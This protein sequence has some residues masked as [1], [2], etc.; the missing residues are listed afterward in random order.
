[1]DEHLIDESVLCAAYREQAKHYSRILKKADAL[2]AAVDNDGNIDELTQQLTG[3][4]DQTAIA[5]RYIKQ[6]KERWKANGK[7]PGPQLQEAL[8]HI[9]HLIKEVIDRVQRAEQEASARQMQLLPEI[10]AQSRRRMMQ[11]VYGSSHKWRP[12]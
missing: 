5:D 7:K 3:A 10:E 2:L 9:G 1:M 4:L 12:R 8:R 6:I 11:R